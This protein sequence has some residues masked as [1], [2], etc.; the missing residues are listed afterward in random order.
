MSKLIRTFDDM[1][2]RQLKFFNLYIQYGNATRA[3]MQ[4]YNTPSHKEASA[5]VLGSRLLKMTREVARVLY[6]THGLGEDT[7]IKILKKAIK[8]TKYRFYQGQKFEFPDHH[9][10]LKAAEMIHRFSGIE[11]EM[12]KGKIDNQFNV[13][14]ISDEKRGIF[15][16][17][18]AQ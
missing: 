12:D 1:N 2:P 10:R 14:I 5:A 9:V 13:Q 3:Y 11:A 7:V 16:V 17:Q 4:A 6:E 8:A 15:R 18:D